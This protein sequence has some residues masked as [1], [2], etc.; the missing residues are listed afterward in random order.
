M[1]RRHVRQ[2]RAVRLH[3]WRLLGRDTLRPG[4]AHRNMPAEPLLA[5]Y[6]GVVR[7]AAVNPPLKAST[8][9]SDNVTL[10]VARPSAAVVMLPSGFALRHGTAAPAP[11]RPRLKNSFLPP[12]PFPAPS[13]S[14][15]MSTGI[16]RMIPSAVTLVLA[17]TCQFQVLAVELPAGSMAVTVNE[18][19]VT[20]GA[21][22][23]SEA[24][25]E[26]KGTATA[27]SVHRNRSAAVSGGSTT[28]YAK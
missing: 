27:S 12:S 21:R 13:V 26:V 11:L 9:S 20:R 15:A 14:L 6:G 3:R 8:K 16:V 18:Y 7:N 1:Q 23:V 19:G 5:R 25:V 28:V 4:P 10:H 24:P 22:P 17:Y 2:Q